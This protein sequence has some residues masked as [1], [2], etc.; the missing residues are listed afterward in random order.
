M[1][2][3]TGANHNTNLC[4][5]V[6]CFRGKI[7]QSRKAGPSERPQREARRPLAQSRPPSAPQKKLR[8]SL[9]AS[10]TTRAPRTWRLRSEIRSLYPRCCCPRGALGL[11][12]PIQEIPSAIASSPV[13]AK[14]VCLWSRRRSGEDAR[15]RSHRWLPTGISRPRALFEF[16]TQSTH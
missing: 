3:E 8:P 6:D 15:R 14:R 11:R 10:Q 13:L 12:Q 16:R 1:F 7:H 5:V 9:F 4:L 2:H